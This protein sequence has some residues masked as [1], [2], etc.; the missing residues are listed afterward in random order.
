MLDKMDNFNT[1][2]RM[3][4]MNFNSAFNSATYQLAEHLKE[5]DNLNRFVDHTR[6]VV[7]TIILMWVFMSI[8]AC[9]SDPFGENL[10]KRLKTV[11]TELSDAEDVINELDEENDKLKAEL[12]RAKVEISEVE[13]RYISCRQAAQRFIDTQPD[14]P[15]GKR[16]RVDSK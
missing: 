3:L 7:T 12:A 11:E 15:C 5:P 2:I 9:C 10:R 14:V 13:A 4:A 1:S 6:F 8:C 16:Q